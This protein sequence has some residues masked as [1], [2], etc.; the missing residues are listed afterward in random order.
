MR[1]GC[2]QVGFQ[3]T[4]RVAHE[5]QTTLPIACPPPS[6]GTIAGNSRGCASNVRWISDFKRG[7][8]VPDTVACGPAVILAFAG[9]R[10][11]RR[12]GG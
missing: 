12:Y 3:S 9:P 11:V 2:G 10:Q 5:G 4:H 1:N 7:G 6:G 8:T